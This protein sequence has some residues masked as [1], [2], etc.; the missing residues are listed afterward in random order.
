[1]ADNDGN[2]VSTNEEGDIAVLVEP[3]RPQGMFKEYKDDLEE[4]PLPE[5]AIGT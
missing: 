2:E 4:L 3:S 1:M 5:K